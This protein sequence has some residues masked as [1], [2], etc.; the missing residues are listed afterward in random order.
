MKHLSF[1]S[2]LKEIIL[3]RSFLYGKWKSRKFRFMYVLR[4]VM[5]PVASIRYY[6]ALQSLTYIEEIL[7]V[8]P[9]LP[10]KI[11]RPYLHK[12]GSVRV[13][14]EYIIGHY[15]FIQE[16][17]EEYF[18]FFLPQ[19]PVSLV[20]FVGKDGEDFNICCS[21]SSFDR[22]GELTLS[23]TF[24]KTP[25]ARLTFSIIPTGN[26]HSAFIGGLQGPPKD[27]GPE[28]IRCATKACYGLFPKRI[29]FEAFCSLMNFCEIT[30]ILAVSENSHVFRQL[31]YRYQKRKSFVAIYS[32][33]WESVAGEVYGRW[34]RL[35]NKTVRKPLSDI[36]SK[37]RSEYRKRYRLLD[38]IHHKVACS[39]Q[40]GMRVQ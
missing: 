10:A 36:A 4:C 11:H 26:G 15:R 8:Q 17:P 38:D 5:N 40:N 34:Y 3:S 30:E 12:G 25:I 39:L 9:V 35:P 6:Y 31:R 33:F 28:V 1:L 19:T 22:E 16:L 7:T 14:E 29:L 27:I 2:F 24:N 20:R 13:R 21:S 23:L 18:V 37:K 32:D